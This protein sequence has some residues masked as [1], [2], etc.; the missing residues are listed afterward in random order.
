MWRFPRRRRART[1]EEAF[2]FLFSL[3][4][5]IQLTPQELS[6]EPKKQ[7]LRRSANSGQKTKRG[8]EG[9]GPFSVF[10]FPTG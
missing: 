9:E 4:H 5:I 10:L 2:F 3:S 7:R 8:I 6:S 1:K